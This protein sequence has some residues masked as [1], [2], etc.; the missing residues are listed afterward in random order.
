VKLR[1]RDQIHISALGPNPIA[2]GS[3]FELSDAQ[4]RGLIKRGLADEVVAEPAPDDAP[5]AEPAEKA[6]PAPQNKAEPAAPANKA[7]TRRKP[8]GE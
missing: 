3:E 7:T 1:A 5:A 4:A 2:P 6:E 8:K